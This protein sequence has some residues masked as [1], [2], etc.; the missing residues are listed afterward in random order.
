MTHALWERDAL[1]P[2]RANNDSTLWRVHWYRLAPLDDQDQDI[3]TTNPDK[4]SAY[5]DA[6][7]NLKRELLVSLLDEPGYSE[8]ALRTAVAKA[9]V[10]ERLKYYV[11][12]LRVWT[13]VYVGDH[14]AVTAHWIEKIEVSQ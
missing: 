12:G 3:Q 1:A 5:L 8:C 11:P 4:Y 14:L 2:I 6:I 10:G 9:W 13:K 7:S